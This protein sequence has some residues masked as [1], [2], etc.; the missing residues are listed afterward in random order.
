MSFITIQKILKTTAISFGVLTLITGISASAFDKPTPEQIQQKKENIKNQIEQIKENRQDIKQERQDIRSERLEYSKDRCET[1][2]SNWINKSTTFRD[3][4]NTSQT[5]MYNKFVEVSAT[6]K[7]KGKDTTK[8][9]S[10]LATLKTYIDTA[11]SSNVAVVTAVNGLD[12]TT[13]ETHKSTSEVI[14]SAQKTAK[15]N[16]QTVR[17]FAKNTIKSD[18]ASLRK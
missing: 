12:C 17:D 14:K 5:K 7:A 18:V 6:L 10:D 9:D 4:E 11:N 13:K 3:K 16:N 15:T 1:H 2:K 8:L